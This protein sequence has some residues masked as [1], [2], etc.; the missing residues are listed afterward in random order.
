MK[1]IE[2]VNHDIEWWD[3]FDA[4]RWV[5]VEYNKESDEVSISGSIDA[6]FRRYTFYVLGSSLVIA[7]ERLEKLEY[8]T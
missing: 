8:G 2:L 3:E 5:I 1:L 7:K 4:K 6:T